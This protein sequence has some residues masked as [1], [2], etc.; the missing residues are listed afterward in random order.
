MSNKRDTGT[1][2]RPRSDAAER[3]IW[4]EFILFV[5]KTLISIK[6]GNDKNEQVIL[7]IGNGPDRRV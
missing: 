6:H 1:Q 2:N 3:D 7:S 5:L 4:S